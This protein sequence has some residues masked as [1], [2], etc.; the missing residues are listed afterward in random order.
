VLPFNLA[1]FSSTS[2]SFRILF[3]PMPD[4]TEAATWTIE[5]SILLCPYQ[6]SL[7]RST[8]NERAIFFATSCRSTVFFGMTKMSH[9]NTCWSFWISYACQILSGTGSLGWLSFTFFSAGQIF[10]IMQIQY[11]G[12]NNI[13]MFLERLTFDPLILAI[14]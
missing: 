14:A 9:W 11:Y 12:L 4:E 6:K 13:Y 7:G 2:Y 5:G 3:Y 10:Q 1:C 8:Y